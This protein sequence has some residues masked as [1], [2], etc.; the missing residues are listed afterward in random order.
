[1]TNFIKYILF[2]TDDNSKEGIF[3]IAKAYNAVIDAAD[4]GAFHCH[5]LIWILTNLTSFELSNKLKDLAFVERLI[6]YIDSIIK[7]EKE[8]DKEDYKIRES[9]SH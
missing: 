2:Y 7:C 9:V 6:E 4:R 3:G 5:M 1:M 8:D